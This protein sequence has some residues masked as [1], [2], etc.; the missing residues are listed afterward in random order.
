MI[1]IVSA[2]FPPE[3]VVSAFLSY[4]LAMSLSK[5]YEVKVLTPRPTRPAGEKYN[6]QRFVVNG[7]EQIILNSYACPKSR[8]IGRMRE[9][10][11]FGLHAR[12]FIKSHYSDI[13]VIYMNAWPLLA[14]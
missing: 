1:L 6:S 14:Q 11:S 2:V 9:S 7:I 13:Q 5:K 12:A 10:F 4:D 8:L 3:P